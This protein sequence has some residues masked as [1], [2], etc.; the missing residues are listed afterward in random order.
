MNILIRKA[1]ISVFSYTFQCT[2][3]KLLVLNISTAYQH[4]F[5]TDIN[6]VRHCLFQISQLTMTLAVSWLCVAVLLSCNVLVQSELPILYPTDPQ[7]WSLFPYGAGDI[8]CEAT[9]D[10]SWFANDIGQ[11]VTFFG[12][13]Y[14]RIRVSIQVEIRCS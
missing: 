10:A 7:D 13:S 6:V 2:C 14:G 3:S 8:E 4:L 12:N 1:D 11:N 5:Y 9:D